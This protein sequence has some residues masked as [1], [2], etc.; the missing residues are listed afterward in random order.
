LVARKLQHRKV[1]TRLD[2]IPGGCGS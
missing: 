2:P 1:S